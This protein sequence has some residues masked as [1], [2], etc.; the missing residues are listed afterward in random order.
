M[1]EP[2]Y[3]IPHHAIPLQHDSFGHIRVAFN[4]SAKA[5][6]GRSLNSEMYA[7][8]KL[9]GN[10]WVITL[11]WRFFRKVGVADIEKMYRQV[12]LDPED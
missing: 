2:A 7:G 6:S 12:L 4:A 11:R 1:S 8:L 9:Q 3:F 5:A 10:L